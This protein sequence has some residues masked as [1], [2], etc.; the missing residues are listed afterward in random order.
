ML[1]LFGHAAAPDRLLDGTVRHP[2]ASHILSDAAKVPG[3]AEEGVKRKETR[4]K[5]TAGKPVIPCAVETW[6]RIDDRLASL[7]DE[8]AV[9]AS[10]RQRDRG[11]LPT[12][13]RAKW[14]TLIST[15]LAMSV[16]SAILHAVPTHVKPCGTLRLQE[17]LRT[18]SR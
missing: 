4:Y 14:R 13:W 17:R 12:R 6:G 16:A 2:A 18:G 7:L 15:K 3:A 8:L 10:Q 11:L 5:P 9:L 1:E